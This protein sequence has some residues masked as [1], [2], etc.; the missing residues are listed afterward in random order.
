MNNVGEFGQILTANLG[1]DASVNVGLEF[2]L[3]PQL[4]LKLVRSE[5]DGVSVGIV[6][7]TV[8]DIKLLANQYLEYIVKEGDLDEAGLWKKQAS[9]DISLTKKTI[10]NA[11][12]FSVLP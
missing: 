6:D 5:A 3:T 7:K 11:E 9:V 4:G 12:T 8:G 1:T 2:T 10:G